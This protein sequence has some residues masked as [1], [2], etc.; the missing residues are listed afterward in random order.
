V[1]EGVMGMLAETV[2][3]S[4]AAV[5]AQKHRFAKIGPVGRRDG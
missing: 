5:E 4:L 3:Q 1:G 2:R